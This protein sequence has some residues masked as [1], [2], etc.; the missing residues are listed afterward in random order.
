MPEQAPDPSTLHLLRTFVDQLTGLFGT[1]MRLVRS[2]LG[3]KLA[4][5]GRA[6]GLLA[7]ALVAFLGGFVLLLMAGAAG[8][9]AAGLAPEWANLAI[10]CIAFALAALLAAR[11]A[12][13][14]SP[15]KLAPRRS[16]AQLGKDADLLKGQPK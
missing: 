9:E 10:A 11:A 16:L 6:A 1:E 5:I 14:L 12:G 7:A 8:L 15:A 13:N 2:E 4:Q 3:E